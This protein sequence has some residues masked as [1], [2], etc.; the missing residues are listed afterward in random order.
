[1]LQRRL[2]FAALF[3][4]YGILLPEISR[5]EGVLEV[6]SPTN[7]Q[8]LHGFPVLVDVELGPET[9]RATFQATLNGTDITASFKDH[10]RGIRATLYLEDGLFFTTKELP[11]GRPNVLQIRVVH[12]EIGKELETKTFFFL[13][14][15]ALKT[16]GPEG[17]NLESAN[18]NL[19]FRI[20]PKTFS[21]PTPIALTE[22]P[23]PAGAQQTYQLSC[24]PVLSKRPTKIRLTYDRDLMPY[25]VGE[26][27]LLLI[28]ED[29]LVK[30]LPHSA[31][32]GTGVLEAQ[33][34]LLTSAKLFLSY[35]LN[36]G[37]S[38]SDIPEATRVRLP[39]GDM[40]DAPY[41][42][43]EALRRRA[44]NSGDSGSNSNHSH[45]GPNKDHP[46]CQWLVRTAYSRNRSVILPGPA[47]NKGYSLGRTLDLFS[48]GE[49]WS[50]SC[51]ADRPSLLP[52]RAIADGLV[53]Y[54]GWEQGEAIVLAHKVNG[55]RFLSMYA[56]RIEASPCPVGTIV[57]GG[58]V[59]AKIGKRGIDRGRLDYAIGDFSLVRIGG[60]AGQIKAPAIWFRHW[61]LG[62]IRD[63]YYDPTH[64]MQNLTGKYL[65]SFNTDGD[66]EG[67]RVT[68]ATN[69]QEGHG[70][71]V[72]NGV[73]SLEPIADRVHV[74]SYPLNID[75]ASFDALFIKMMVSY[76]VG[77]GIV[78]YTTAE[79]PDFTADRSVTFDILN[80]GLNEYEISME[81]E[82]GWAGTISG[83]RIELLGLAAN[84]RQEI[85]IDEIRLGRGFLSRLP[86]T[87]QVTCYDL[88][89]PIPCPDPG[90]PFFGQDAQYLNHP[91]AYTASPAGGVDTVLDEV[92]GLAW[93]SRRDSNPKNWMDAA[94][95]A[96]L[97]DPA[98]WRLPT[99]KEFQT[100]LDFSTARGCTNATYFHPPV[101]GSGRFWSA[102]TPAY[103]AKGAWAVSLTDCH[104]KRM[105]KDTLNHVLYVMGRPLNF[106]QFKDNGNDTVTD[107]ATGLM[108]Y[109]LE[110]KAMSWP[111][112]LA[113]C[114]A[115]DTA[116]HNDWR[117]P[118]I[119]E[120]QSIVD[121]EMEGPTLDSAYFPGCRPF[122]YWSSTTNAAHPEFAWHVNFDDGHAHGGGLKTREYYVRPVRSVYQ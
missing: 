28:M 64:F 8:K 61:T 23:S 69:S 116:G 16:I 26:E 63:K 47:E 33:L 39:I 54:N 18:G 92:T 27:D 70:Y 32:Q 57:H 100:L 115:L 6:L 96:E 7:F 122:I 119:K 89:Q 66:R 48:P 4:T 101:D 93:H 109:G 29:D 41:G 37:H 65:W 88:N 3:F 71:S 113:F 118:N 20:P 78:Y 103:L 106:A 121:V 84:P 12:E 75:A 74:T 111:D 52:V 99:L 68:G 13:E 46:P 76:P 97:S 43:G 5:A 67:W 2:L 22:L 1:M 14:F 90:E 108:W 17:G 38:V 58:E 30:H 50:Y 117:L 56:N 62:A 31:I 79:T 45:V 94:D 40:G 25:D 9:R 81:D 51:P 95:H 72:E 77:E 80:G 87:G 98:G 42:C 55:V 107:L 34:H 49:I 112:A 86:D 24:R 60:K 110:T 83:I 10:S 102:T 82:T 53:I 120:L 21:A 19:L 59:I 114:E 44:T 105:S 35:Y 36:T 104:V 11:E 91:P 73:L 15:E 85:R